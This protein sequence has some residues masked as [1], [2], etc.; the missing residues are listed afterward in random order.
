VLGVLAA[1]PDWSLLVL[2]VEVVDAPD[3][4]VLLLGVDEVAAPD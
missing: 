3:G 4:S 1:A 2:G